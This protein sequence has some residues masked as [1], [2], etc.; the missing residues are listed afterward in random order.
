MY[1]HILMYLFLFKKNICWNPYIFVCKN[2]KI[3]SNINFVYS[4]SDYNV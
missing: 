2:F 1:F 4:L 3:E